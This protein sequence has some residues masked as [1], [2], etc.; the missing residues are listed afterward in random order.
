M[1]IKELAF[2]LQRS[3]WKKV[4]WREGTNK[5]FVFALCSS[6]GASGAS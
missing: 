6:A 3:A 1:S 4:A 2:A 5:I